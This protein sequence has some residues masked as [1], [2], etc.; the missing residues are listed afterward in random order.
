MSWATRD[1][2][3]LA[4]DYTPAAALTNNVEREALATMYEMRGYAFTEETNYLANARQNLMDVKTHLK[5]AKDLAAKGGSNNLTCLRG[6]AEKA[7]TGALEY[8]QL[9]NQTVEETKALQAD[10]A[11]M[12]TEA[13]AF[14]KA[15]DEYLNAQAD[16]MKD[17]VN[18]LMALVD[19][20]AKAADPKAASRGTV[21]KRANRPLANTTTLHTGNGHGLKR[22]VQPHLPEM[23]FSSGRHDHPAAKDSDC[24]NS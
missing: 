11:L 17:V 3:A 23:A 5:T 22:E 8:E 24:E 19:G 14:L 4:E 7:E 21:S 9:A 15:S 6:A 18:S 10:R 12:N 16:A 2:Q 1:A 13:Q 20:N